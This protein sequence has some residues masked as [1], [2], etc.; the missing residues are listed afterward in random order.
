MQMRYSGLLYFTAEQNENL[1]YIKW[2]LN[3]NCIKLMDTLKSYE[4]SSQKND[5]LNP[6]LNE[7]ESCSDGQLWN[8]Q[9]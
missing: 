4:I 7:I 8:E 9:I 2:T 6:S 1:E 5:V 3:K